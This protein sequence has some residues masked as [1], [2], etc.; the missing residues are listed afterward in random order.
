MTNIEI[1]LANNV[2]AVI[3]VWAITY[4]MDYYLMIIGARIYAA[5]A[6]QHFLF[7][8]GYEITPEFREDVNALRLISQRLLRYLIASSGIILIVWLVAVRVLRYEEVFSVLIGG[9][10]LRE[11]AIYLR[12]IRN[13]AL[14]ISVRG[15]KGARGQVLYPR[16]LTL[17]I[18]G[19]ELA[20]FSL[21]YLLLF[22]LDKSWFFFGGVVACAATA[23][24]HL[25]VSNQT[26]NREPRFESREEDENETFMPDQ[27]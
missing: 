26:I 3:I 8:E 7:E 11:A 19:I 20:S 9:L 13:I 4:A 23:I 5:G 25:S 2:G 27:D 21:L 10:F 14:F 18:S 22:L 6:K 16:W 15:E 24:Q 1:F 12:Q 17:R